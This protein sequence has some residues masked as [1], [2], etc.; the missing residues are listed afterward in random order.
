MDLTEVAIEGCLHG[1]ID[2]VY[3]QVSRLQKKVGDKFDLLIICGDFQA[4]RDQL[5][6]D[7]MHCPE[8]YKQMGTFRDYY[9]GR[10]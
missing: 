9:E 8:K 6:L 1:E 10:K 4:I 7:D 3:A 2:E 5:D